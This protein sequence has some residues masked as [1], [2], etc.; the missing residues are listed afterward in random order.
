MKKYH[1]IQTLFNR[2]SSTNYK[3][4]IEGSFSRPEF[5]YLKSNLWIFTEKV[6]GTNIRVI[7][8]GLD[9]Q[10]KGKTDN[11]QV[12]PFLMNVLTEKFPPSKFKAVFKDTPATLYGEGYGAKIQKGGG[13]Y[14]SNTQNFILFD[15]QVDNI[16]LRFC[17]VQDI[18]GN[19]EID[20]VP[21]IQTGALNKAVALCM[22][23]FDSMLRDTFPEGLVM[24]PHENLYNHTGER[25]ITKLKL[26]DFTI[27]NPGFMFR[28]TWNIEY[29]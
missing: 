15:V 21:I 10:F 1:K 24:R 23:G 6:D 7:Y 17:D 29:K 11:A 25:V 27:I 4:I 13:D 14:I 9:V 18:G 3:T 26:K 16:W 5:E 19:L 22:D 20:I 28:N 8:D 2:D 12:P